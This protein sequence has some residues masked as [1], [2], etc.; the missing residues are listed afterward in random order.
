MA[1]WGAPG[2]LD[3]HAW[4]SCVAAMRI[5]RGMDALNERWQAEGLKPLKI[6]MGIHS[7]AVLV[8]NI[9]SKE[10]MSYTVMGDGVNIAARLEGTNKEFHTRIL[11][12]HSVFKEAGERLCVRPVD[13][14]T[15]KGRR[16]KVPIYELMGVYGADDPGWSRDPRP[17]GWPSSRG[18]AMRL[19]SR[20]TTLWHRGATRDTGGVSRRSSC[21][22]VGQTARDGLGE[23]AVHGEG[24]WWGLCPGSAFLGVIDVSK[25][26]LVSDA[27]SE[28]ALAALRPS[29]YTAALIQVLHAKSTMVQGQGARSRVGQRRRPGGAGRAGRGFAVRHRIEEDAVASGMAAVGR[30]WPWR[31]SG[32]LPWRHVVAG[33]RASLRPDRGQSAALPYGAQRRSRPPAEMERRRHQRPRPARSFPRRAGRA[34]GRR[35]PRHH[36]P[37]RLRRPR[38][39]A[40]DPGQVRPVAQRRAHHAGLH[41]RRQALAHDASVLAV[42]DGRTI[43]RYGPYAFGEMHI[44]EIT[45]QQVAG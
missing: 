2:L 44:V 38:P 19:W 37:Q 6:R 41:S 25:P 15:V 14:V 10:R 36:H 43:H 17:S 12:S 1:F 11:I 45:K 5:Q 7:D 18:L 24:H 23:I 3:D 30:A 33:R 21:V 27:S 32:A 28:L 16:S 42:Q 13:D 20:R 39:H 22:D 31:G 29:E 35:W 8:G 4:R 9:G 26:R 40:R 34:S